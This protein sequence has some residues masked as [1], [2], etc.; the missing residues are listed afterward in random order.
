MKTILAF[1]IAILLSSSC[2]FAEY[3]KYINGVYSGSY[4]F[5]DVMVTIE[6]NKIANIEIMRHGGGGRR[7]EEMVIPLIDKI[8]LN[9]ATGIDAVTGATVSSENL[10]KAVDMALSQAVQK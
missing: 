8:I 7:Y 1:V 6:G 10:L 4:S 3:I 9:Q 2:S 5:V